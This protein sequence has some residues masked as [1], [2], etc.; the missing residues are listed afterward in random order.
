[1][2]IIYAILMFCV[3]IFI[4]EFGHFIAAKKCGIRVN[5]FALGMGPALIKKQRGETTYSLRAFP[6]GGFCAMEGEDEDSEDPRAFNHKKPWQ[7]A[8]VVCAGAA[9]NVILAII[10]MCIVSY[11]IGVASTT[12]DSFVKGSHAAADGM[13]AGDKITAIDGTAIRAWDDVSKALDNKKKNETVAITVVRDGRTQTIKTQLMENQNRAMIGISPKMVKDPGRSII[14]GFTSTWGLTKSMYV[15]IKQMVTGKVAMNQMS[16]P[17]G[18]VYMVNKSASRGFVYFL[19]LMALISLNLGVFNM[20]PFPALDGGRLVF[21]IVRSF[22]GK[23]ITDAV[24]N[25]INFAGLVLLF[26]LMIYVTW[27]DVIK[28]IVPHFQ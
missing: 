21:I 12:V 1:M 20:L 7:K 15:I 8:I 19:Y 9:M 14:T 11:T 28:F 4:H 22:T 23:A 13:R 5:E 24:E 16:G 3:L 18:I 6:I 26:G 27:N 17:V 25:R 2:T 10:L